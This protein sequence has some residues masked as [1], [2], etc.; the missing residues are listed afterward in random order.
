MY[1]KCKT[2]TEIAW[3]WVETRLLL[4]NQTTL[5][6]LRYHHQYNTRRKVGSN[7][8]S[9]EKHFYLLCVFTT[10]VTV[11]KPSW[12]RHRHW[13]HC[14]LLWNKEIR[15]KS[16]TWREFIAMFPE[17][18]LWGCTGMEMW[19]FLWWVHQWN[20]RFPRM[21]FPFHIIPLFDNN[22][23]GKPLS[24]ISIILRCPYS[25]WRSLQ[26]FRVSDPKS[27]RTRSYVCL[28]LTQRSQ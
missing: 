4:S 7:P 24:C 12:L 16:K 23:I 15:Y 21:T 2:N 22:M 20:P 17:G 1:A 5:G 19:L 11:E 26:H 28:S 14:I 25:L 6:E 10:F 18:V 13:F 9:R 3:N 27:A 8:T